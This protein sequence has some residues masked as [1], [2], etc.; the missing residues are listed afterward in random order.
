MVSFLSWFGTVRQTYPCSVYN[1]LNQ[2]GDRVAGPSNGF[3]GLF[4]TGISQVD[5]THLKKIHWEKDSVDIVFSTLCIV[6]N[7][8]KSQ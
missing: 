1:T 3:H 6:I 7:W 8:N 4:M 2:E 5:S